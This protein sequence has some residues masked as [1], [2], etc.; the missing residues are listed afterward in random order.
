MGKA[1]I[2]GSGSEALSANLW[3]SSCGPTDDWRSF[4]IFFRRRRIVYR[5]R[6]RARSFFEAELLSFG[7]VPLG[8]DYWIH[9]VSSVGD[10]Y[11][12]RVVCLAEARS[13]LE[14]PVGFSPIQSEWGCYRGEW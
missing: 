6:V 12:G 3:S 2:G 5:R 11:D 10:S 14:S 13:L 4:D 9:R 7:V 1:F 8:I